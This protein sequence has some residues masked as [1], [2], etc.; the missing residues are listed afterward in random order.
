MLE[1]R[2]GVHRVSVLLTDRHIIHDVLVS[3]NRVS[4]VFGED[5]IPFRADEVEALLD[6]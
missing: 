1:F 5:T 6:K 2:M 3:G 4:W